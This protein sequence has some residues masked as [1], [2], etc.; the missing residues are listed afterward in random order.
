MRYH[1]WKCDDGTYDVVDRD[2]P[3]MSEDGETYYGPCLVYTNLPE[4]AAR[5]VVD[6]LNGIAAKAKAKVKPPPPP[7]T[8]EERALV[9]A[10]AALVEAAK[11]AMA[12]GDRSLRCSEFYRVFVSDARLTKLLIRA[13]DEGDEVRQLIRRTQGEKP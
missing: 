2:E 10:A 1:L 6:H 11:E 13:L 9:I 8:E 3:D 12:A 5:I 7:L 4:S